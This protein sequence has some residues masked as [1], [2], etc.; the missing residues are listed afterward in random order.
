MMVI[1]RIM[2]LQVGF[3]YSPTEA[4]DHHGCVHGLGAMAL[5]DVLVFN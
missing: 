2:M 5:G 4:L 3:S 1:G